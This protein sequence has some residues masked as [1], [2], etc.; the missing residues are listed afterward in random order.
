M[1]VLDRWF[2]TNAPRGYVLDVFD[3]RLKGIPVMAT[4][5]ISELGTS[6]NVAGDSYAIVSKARGLA[7]SYAFPV[8]SAADLVTDVWSDAQKGIVRLTLTAYYNFK[9][10]RDANFAIR[11]LARS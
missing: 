2:R 1:E 4:D 9:V 8:W 11:R 5:H 6:G 7:G 10:I 3:E